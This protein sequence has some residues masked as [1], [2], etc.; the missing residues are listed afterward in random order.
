MPQSSTT[1]AAHG[2]PPKKEKDKIHKEMVKLREEHVANGGSD[3]RLTLD[4]DVKLYI[5]APMSRAIM[6]ETRPEPKVV[7][8][9]E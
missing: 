6:A 4:Q 5:L 3:E 7:V 8:T 1:Y 2:R 9:P